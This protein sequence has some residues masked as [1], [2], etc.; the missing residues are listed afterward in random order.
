MRRGLL[1]KKLPTARWGVK[2]NRGR[3]GGIVG[4]RR[5]DA[6]SNAFTNTINEAME[7]LGKANFF[8]DSARERE[9][10]GVEETPRIACGAEL[11]RWVG[12]IGSG[13]SPCVN[14]RRAWIAWEAGTHLGWGPEMA[15]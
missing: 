10:R 9:R 13:A 2:V 8:D 5:L 6:F 4:D 11:L 15:N 7:S 1:E 14:S 12:P 3:P